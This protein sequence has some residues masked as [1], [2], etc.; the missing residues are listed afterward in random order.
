MAGQTEIIEWLED[1]IPEIN[2]TKNP[3]Q[4]CLDFAKSAN[5]PSAKLEKLAHVFNTAKTI[6]YLDKEASESEERAARF[7]LIDVDSL[8]E[9]F[10]S[11]DLEKAASIQSQVHL[12]QDSSV[13]PNMFQ[14]IEGSVLDTKADAEVTTDGQQ[15]KI[16]SHGMNV[17]KANIDRLDQ[18]IFESQE[19][20]RSNFDKLAYTL[21]TDPELDYATIESN[22]WKLKGDDFKT[23]V[24]DK[25][26]SALTSRHVKLERATEKNACNLLNLDN[27]IA[28]MVLNVAEKYDF[29]KAGQA[30]L[31]EME[32]DFKKKASERFSKVA[33]PALDIP[34]LDPK[35]FGNQG[36]VASSTPKEEE[37]K[38]EEE[39]PKQKSNKKEQKADPVDDTMGGGKKDDSKRQS[40]GQPKQESLPKFDG[41]RVS[42]LKGTVSSIFSSLRNRYNHK[43]ETYDSQLM[44]DRLRDNYQYLRMM[45][46]ILSEAE[47]PQMLDDIYMTLVENAPRAMQNKQL[48]ANKL[49]KA[50][51]YGGLDAMDLKEIVELERNLTGLQ[52][53]QNKL[54]KERYG[55]E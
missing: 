12:D 10:N 43:Q 49:R 46:P 54:N 18:I 55:I 50:V 1:L 29:Q 7:S 16:A 41:P 17:S 30:L 38:K 34:G 21:R 45:D 33:G 5:L 42:E 37:D 47:D 9:K 52:I 14:E 15:V 6:S 53:D 13:F 11:G 28:R 32:E 20:L 31:E 36:S 48:M 27:D 8:L 2:E 39:K 4:V 51:E 44:Q 25:V 24:L 35:T 19:E 23:N 26:A 40:K 3:E 22:V